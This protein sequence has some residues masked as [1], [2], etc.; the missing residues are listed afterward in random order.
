VKVNLDELAARL[1]ESCGRDAN[2]ASAL[3]REAYPKMRAIAEVSLRQC[4]DIDEADDI[5]IDSFLRVFRQFENGCEIPN[6]SA[7][8]AKTVRNAVMTHHRTSASRGAREV[9]WHHEQ[10]LCPSDPEEDL[11][12]DERLHCLL[13]AVGRLAPGQ[14]EAV[15]LNLAGHSHQTSAE[16]MGV[17]PAAARR[18]FSDALRSLREIIERG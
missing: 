14:S 1:H 9:R 2:A 13:R 15:M 7:Y 8:L 12:F 3:V 4:G 18:R 6:I 10:A 16:V 17:T 11:D 5:V